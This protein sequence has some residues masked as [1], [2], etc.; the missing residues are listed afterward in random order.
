MNGSEDG[1]SRNSHKM[2]TKRPLFTGMNSGTNRPSQRKDPD[3]AWF[4]AYEAKKAQALDNLNNKN[5]QS[6][7]GASAFCGK[8][9]GVSNLT[10]Q[11]Q[12]TKLMKKLKKDEKAPKIK[13]VD[14]TAESE[15]RDNS[16]TKVDP[17]AGSSSTNIPSLSGSKPEISSSLFGATASS[18]Q[19][20]LQTGTGLSNGYKPGNSGM[21][22]GSTFF[23]Q[24]K[25]GQFGRGRIGGDGGN[26]W[27]QPVNTGGGGGSGASGSQR[28]SD[29][30]EFYIKRPA[31]P[32][33]ALM[34]PKASQIASINKKDD[35]SN[36]SAFRSKPPPP[37]SAL[38]SKY[39]SFNKGTKVK[40]EPPPI[41][42]SACLKR[43]FENDPPIQVRGFE[44][45]GVSSTTVGR[46]GRPGD[47]KFD[48]PE[49]RPGR[50]SV[51]T[52]GRYGT[53]YGGAPSP[54]PNPPQ[55]FKPPGTVPATPPTNKGT[56]FSDS[57]PVKSEFGSSNFNSNSASNDY[58]NY[59]QSKQAKLSNNHQ[60]PSVN[61]DFGHNQNHSGCGEVGSRQQ[62][63]FQPY[64]NRQSG[65]NKHNASQGSHDKF[66]SHSS[67]GN[68]RDSNNRDSWNRCNTS[69][70]ES[71]SQQNSRSAG[72]NNGWQGD[73]DNQRSNHFNQR[74]DNS[75][76]PGQWNTSKTNARAPTRQDYSYQNQGEHN[77]RK[78]RWDSRD[79]VTDFQQ[80]YSNQHHSSYN[81]SQQ[82]TNN[83]APVWNKGST[84][85]NSG[86]N[87]FQNGPPPPP[88]SAAPS[89][90]VPPPAFFGCP[91]PPP[92]P[93][94]PSTNIKEAQPSN[95]TPAKDISFSK[96]LK[97]VK[98]DCKKDSG[99]WQ[100]E[101]EA[102]KRSRLAGK[103]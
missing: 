47:I 102:R 34:E 60:Q 13:F 21:G 1:N 71:Y 73:Y 7:S 53:K 55:A 92:P 70:A 36:E 4:S 42:S 63:Q 58:S 103:M 38:V 6:V 59:E 99:S 91:P 28:P 37:P 83:M 98:V 9:E 65:N 41:S 82:V 22:T 100:E 85:P 33:S 96:A 95:N 51:P 67:W 26:G 69:N 24:Q 49:G 93:K 57:L 66:S 11:N 48:S 45:P 10:A 101:Y 88:A 54:G 18:A 74:N 25:P 27:G 89:F 81:P 56:A 94:V 44:P 14:K 35:T 30:A 8:I 20:T 50:P 68:N 31:A 97:N 12:V 39:G 29:A 46:A 87:S 62:S 78:S 80:N 32:T 17:L 76:N 86:H 84:L 77:E 61:T 43:K 5:L 19:S 52:P 23:G 2:N 40:S 3:D 64:N 72:H 90:S 75:H 79:K 16:I 15:K